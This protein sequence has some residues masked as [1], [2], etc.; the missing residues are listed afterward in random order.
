MSTST[1]V[2]RLGITNSQ[3]ELRLHVRHDF[4]AR[5]LECSQAIRVEDQMFLKFFWHKCLKTCKLD[6]VVQLVLHL[7]LVAR[8][9]RLQ[10]FDHRSELH[11]RAPSERD[12]R[13]QKVSFPSSC[14]RIMSLLQSPPCLQRVLPRVGDNV[15]RLI[16]RES[17]ER[18]MHLLQHKLQVLYSSVLVRNSR[19]IAVAVISAGC[20][21]AHSNIIS[22]SLITP[23]KNASVFFDH[24]WKS[25][26]RPGNS[27][28]RS[29]PFT[30]M[31][32]GVSFRT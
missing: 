32:L 8:H 30:S 29:R 1:R 20:S 17:H 22:D 26:S 16:T 7:L 19:S 24:C 5:I 14:R 31:R 6:L 27:F 18:C 10:A 25:S 3:T 12:D 28:G 23:A 13:A 11:K 15:I 21:A 4:Q 2:T 9:V